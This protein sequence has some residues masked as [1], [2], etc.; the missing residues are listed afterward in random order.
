VPFAVAGSI[1][2]DHLMHFPGRF[3]EQILPEQLHQI[4]VSFLVDDLEIHRGGV[5]ANIAYSMGVLGG[6]PLLVGAAGQDF[7]E[8]RNFLESNGVDCSTVQIS[9]TKHTARFTCTTDDDMCQISSFYAGAMAEAGQI[10]LAPIVERVGEFDL[11]LISPD[12]PDA[13]VRH[14]QECRDR[15][16]PFAADPSQQLARMDGEQ[17]RE[18]VDGAKFLFSNDYEWE[19]LLNK[20]GWTEADVLQ[21]V[22]MRV[23]T[24]GDKGVQIIGS[25]GTP[26]K[27]G[28]VPAIAKGNPT[29]AGD[30]F[31]GGFLTA[32]AGG[33]SLERAC[34]LG[35]LI[36]VLSFETV[37]PQDWTFDR[38]SA[39]RR[40]EE[41]Y[42]ADAAKEL[43][44]ILPS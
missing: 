3:A 4:S 8:Y 30:A 1:A 14:A 28:P 44:A 35:A 24:L 9:K 22:G 32:L 11:V 38:G 12:A 31:R 19:L 20:T 26:I 21:R 25:D 36:G 2:T 39:L 27:V 29:G 5:G 18:L 15:G 42:G 10:E 33:L 43:G 17:V 6:R 40:L 13:M 37:G 34:Q 23:T 16:Y 7:D 41:A